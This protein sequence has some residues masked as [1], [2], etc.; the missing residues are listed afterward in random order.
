MKKGDI[1]KAGIIV[2]VVVGFF[3]VIN[4]TPDE[5]VTEPDMDFQETLE[6]TERQIEEQFQTEVP[7]GAERAQL[8]GEEVDGRALATRD[9]TEEGTNISVLADLP[10]PEQGMF[11]QAWAQKG[12]EEDE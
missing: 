10:D 12:D 1:V 2:A 7:E 5:D 6:E 4:Q 3:Y 8:R 9:V 11:Y